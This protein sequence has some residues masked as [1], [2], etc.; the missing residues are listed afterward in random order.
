MDC[1]VCEKNGVIPNQYHCSKCNTDVEQAIASLVSIEK[2]V[3]IAIQKIRNLEYIHILHNIKTMFHMPVHVALTFSPKSAAGCYEVQIAVET[4]KTD[5]CN[6]TVLLYCSQILY[7]IQLRHDHIQSTKNMGLVFV[8]AVLRLKHLRFSVSLSELEL[9]WVKTDGCIEE[10]D[11]FCDSVGFDQYEQLSECA[12]CLQK[13]SRTMPCRHALC[14]SCHLQLRSRHAT[15]CPCCRR[16][17][18]D[19][20]WSPD[21]ADSDGS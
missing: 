13:T 18:S 17:I 10:L 11:T 3:E 20:S 9:D 19:G 14:V 4:E 16:N 7:S 8:Y 21:D 1:A 15:F 2:T 6:F 5:A 12:V